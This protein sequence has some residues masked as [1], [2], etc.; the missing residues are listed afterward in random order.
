MNLHKNQSNNKGNFAPKV[1]V[2]NLCGLVTD[3]LRQAP[4][5]YGW[6]YN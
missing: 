2:K 6:Q 3:Y 4:I 5:R 1:C